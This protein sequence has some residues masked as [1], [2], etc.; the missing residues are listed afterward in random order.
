MSVTL[1]I[2][3][4]SV[5]VVV[6]ILAACAPLQIYRDNL[7][8]CESAEPEAECTNNAL[9]AYV[10]PNAP[11]EGYTLGFI[12]FDDQGEL[13]S[14]K[15]MWSVLDLANTRAAS[16]DVLMIV[17]VHGWKHSAAPGDPNIDTFRKALR[18][19]SRLE[20]SLARKTER[21]PR[22]L[23]G[24]YLGWRGASVDVAGLDN[25]T[26]WDRKKTAHKVGLG[27]VTE[28]LGRL[29]AI[30]RVKDYQAGGKDK[31][32][33]RLV[34]VG[35][36][37]GGAVVFSAL[38]Q[39]VDDRFVHTVGPDGAVTD[40]DG[41]GDLV[42]LLNP[43]FEALQF[44]SLSDMTTERRTYFASQ[45]PVMAI[46]TS[47]GD[48]ATKRAFPIGRWFSTFWEKTRDVERHNPV[49]NSDQLI[50][51][52]DANRQAIGHFE[53]YRS[54]DLA[55]VDNGELGTEQEVRQYAIS[56]QQWENDKPGSVIEFTGTR[57]TRTDD[58]AGRIPI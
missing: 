50:D 23:F 49:I 22:H 56:S 48:M 35:H 51:Q 40:A 2:R 6:L 5:S 36:S 15:Q 13:W 7:S 17:F 16:E 47:T 55:P 54:H 10:D 57:L 28:V 18:D 21:Q 12:E 25:I 58:S 1:S 11:D 42:V 53:P 20:S 45:L 34:I 38:S 29:E 39:I 31:S 32:S 37:F 24:V 33:T 46:L 52:K 8:L 9:Q 19:Q 26:F 3:A 43:A 4:V 14:R 44:S 30:K 27:D 41:F